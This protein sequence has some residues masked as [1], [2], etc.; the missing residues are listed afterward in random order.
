MGFTALDGLMMATRAGRLDPGILLYLL[1]ERGMDVRGLSDMLYEQCG[2][3]GVS[4]T[5]TDMSELIAS[6][7]PHAREAVALYVDSV[8]RE[9]GALIAVL[10]GLDALVFT[11]GIG[12]HAA[13]VRARVC[14]AFA[15]LGIEIDA[16]ANA[17]HAKCISTSA[18]GAKVFVVPTDE[19]VVIARE[20]ARV[21]AAA[22]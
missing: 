22:A 16:A 18:S 15:W 9:A 14:A 3:L 13:E 4:G 17:Q 1:Q 10:G 2:L 6:A 12:E 11:A 21:A 8:V 19:E 20:T 5:S 7:H